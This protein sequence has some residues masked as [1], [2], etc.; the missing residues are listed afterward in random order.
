MKKG[1]LAV[2]A[3]AVVVMFASVAVAATSSPCTSC[4]KPCS[5]CAKGFKLPN[6]F[7]S[8]C[9]S[10]AKPCSTCAKP[11][12]PCSPCAKV[13]DG[14]KRDVL[15]NKIPVQTVQAGNALTDKA[16]KYEENLISGQ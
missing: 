11:C 6:L 1:V 4:A 9:G 5:T 3:I 10:C 12:A 16:T 13:C 14:F 2:M 8:S 15:G 7:P